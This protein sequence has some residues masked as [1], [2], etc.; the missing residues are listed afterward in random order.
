MQDKVCSLNLMLKYVRMPYIQVWSTE[1]DH[2]VPNQGLHHQ[3]LWDLH[4]S[5]TYTV[6]SGNS[7]QMFWDNL[8]IPA[9]RIKKS[10]RE[11]NTTDITWNNIFLGLYPSPNFLK[12]YDISEADSVSV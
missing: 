11:K 3:I 7:L 5:G 1:L 8:L 4:S 2:A 6:H 10:K 9:S 12:M